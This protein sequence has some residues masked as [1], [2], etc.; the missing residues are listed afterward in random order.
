MFRSTTEKIEFMGVK[1]RV[2]IV[3][4][5]PVFRHGLRQVIH[6][7]PS[8]EVV[9]EAGDDATALAEIAKAKPAVVIV[10]VRLP[11]RGGLELV[12][13][14]RAL[15]PGPACLMLTMHGEEAMFNAAMDAGARG[16]LLKEDAL[17]LVLLGLKAVSA[18][19]FYLSPAISGWLLRRQQRV[20]ALKEQKMGLTALTP[21][22]RRVLQFVAENKTNKEIAGELF[23][24]HRTVE[25][26]RSNICQKLELQG[27]HKLL[28]FAI[29]HRSEL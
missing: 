21:T 27:V 13:A 20:A 9:G 19:S 11:Q 26:H 2:Y 25:T 22:E 4:D 6:A 28:Q 12:K 23:I 7:D 18:G 15:R 16:Y 1:T 24:S 8:F 29:E 17:E 3:D 14:L 5:H 10:D